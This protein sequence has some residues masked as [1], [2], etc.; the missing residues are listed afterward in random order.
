MPNLKEEEFGQIINSSSSSSSRGHLSE[1]VSAQIKPQ[2]CW[3]MSNSREFTLCNRHTHSS[4]QSHSLAS[5]QKDTEQHQ[6][7][8]KTF[9]YAGSRR[10]VQK[11]EE[12]EKKHDHDVIYV[13]ICCHCA[14]SSRTSTQ[15]YAIWQL[16]S[17][18]LAFLRF[19]LHLFFSGLLSLSFSKH[20][21]LPLSTE[22][23]STQC[24]G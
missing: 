2:L 7:A 9:S 20:G 22:V 12:K 23:M 5:H 14:S 6:T 15:L 13:N 3:S 8:K 4:N 24:L 17:G 19:F 21:E 10:L 1:V 18:T 11:V 16:C